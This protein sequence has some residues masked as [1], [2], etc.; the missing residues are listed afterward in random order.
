MTEQPRDYPPPTHLNEPTYEAVSPRAYC[1]VCE[2]SVY[3]CEC[4]VQV[5]PEAE[6]I[7]HD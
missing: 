4:A 1:P 6:D 3:Q 2:R 5:A 7:H